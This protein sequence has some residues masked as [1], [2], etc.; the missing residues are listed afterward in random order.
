[1]S[2]AH[3]GDGPTWSCG[4][5]DGAAGSPFGAMPRREAVLAMSMAAD[6]LFG[7]AGSEGEQGSR[8]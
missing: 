3:L 5:P 4:M 2:L 8:A 6:A 7:P 1:M